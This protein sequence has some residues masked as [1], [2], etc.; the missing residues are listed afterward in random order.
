MARKRQ[1]SSQELLEAY[2]CDPNLA[3][4]FRG[5]AMQRLAALD[6]AY[7]HFLVLVHHRQ[8]FSEHRYIEFKGGTMYRK[9]FFGLICRMSVDL[10]FD[11]PAELEYLFWERLPGATSGPFTFYP[12][13]TSRH[14]GRMRIVSEL[15]PGGEHS[16]H[17]DL[18][19]GPR[20]MLPERKVMLPFPLDDTYSQPQK[21]WLPTRPIIE[22]TAGKL[23]RWYSRQLI[24]DFADFYRL[25]PHLKDHI[26]ELAE[27]M[28]CQA[29]IGDRIYPLGDPPTKNQLLSAIPRGHDLIARLSDLAETKFVLN[30][31]TYIPDLTEGQKREILE[32]WIDEVVSLTDALDETIYDDERLLLIVDGG[33]QS[34]GLAKDLENELRARYGTEHEVYR[35]GQLRH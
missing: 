14:R 23:N 9:S 12:Y 1:I 7:G 13:L 10:D 22:N 6:L 5:E 35:T 21:P 20:L 19:S 18:S 30:D 31:L 16:E 8:I 24:R 25:A 34:A 27:V 11:V 4:T 17:L 28:V 2:G 29:N 15:F 3:E 26:V 32:T 33:P